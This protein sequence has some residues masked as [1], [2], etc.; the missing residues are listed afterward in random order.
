MEDRLKW[1]AAINPAAK[2]RMPSEGSPQ[3]DAEKQ[4]WSLW[5]L[6]CDFN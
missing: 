3:D 5:F 4:S 2:F 6:M 1:Q